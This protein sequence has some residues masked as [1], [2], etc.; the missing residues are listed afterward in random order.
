MSGS[1]D[2]ALLAALA[3]ALVVVPLAVRSVEW[4]AECRASSAEFRLVLASRLVESWST[5]LALA[6]IIEGRRRALERD[7]PSP[8]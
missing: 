6:P 3:A 8:R 2:A 5:P 4:L 1:A 7:Y